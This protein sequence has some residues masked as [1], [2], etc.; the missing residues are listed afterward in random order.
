M[1]I[2]PEGGDPGWSLLC[3]DRDNG[4]E[5]FCLTPLSGSVV[6]RQWGVLLPPRMQAGGVPSGA[7]LLMCS[8]WVCPVSTAVAE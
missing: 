2:R 3:W 1:G 5:E 7:L 6:L 4:A 8:R